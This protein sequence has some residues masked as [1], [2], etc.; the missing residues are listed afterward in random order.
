MV[1]K[2]EV[3]YR[4]AQKSDFPVVREF[5]RQKNQGGW[6][7]ESKS[8]ANRLSRM[9]FYQYMIA[10][11]VFLV[12]VYR[13]QVVGVIL[14]G[15]EKRRKFAPLYRLKKGCVHMLLRMTK[16]GR[17]NL[18]ILAQ[19]RDMRKKLYVEGK[20]EDNFILFFYVAKNYSRNGIGTGLLEHLRE[21]KKD[22]FLMYTEHRDNTAFI[23]KRGFVKMSDTVQMMEV[24][25]RRFRETISLYRCGEE[26]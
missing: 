9:L 1:L 23:E 18:K 16:E 19:L 17:T 6:E 4:K 11:D 13:N 26:C 15:S 14:T 21:T 2:K 5:I 12:A 25:K 3:I 20:R 24:N 10:R 7:Y 8:T 22:S